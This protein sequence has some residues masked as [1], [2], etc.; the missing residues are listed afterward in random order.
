MILKTTL[1]QKGEEI[2]GGE[3]S[4]SLRHR[5]GSRKALQA[6]LPLCTANKTLEP[7]EA[8]SK[9][10]GPADDDMTKVKRRAKC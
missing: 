7:K 2:S 8:S 10:R 1:G 9:E 4:P 5:E 3:L 6:S